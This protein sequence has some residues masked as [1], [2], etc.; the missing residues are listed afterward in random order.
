MSRNAPPK[1]FLWG[2]GV[3]GALRDI[4]KT[5]AKETMVICP[6]QDIVTLPS[7]TN[8]LYDTVISNAKS[9]TLA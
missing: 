2:E 6:P 9:E 5:A 8:V 4:Q 3:G 1:D 7:L